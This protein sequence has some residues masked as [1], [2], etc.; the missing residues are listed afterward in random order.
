MTFIFRL[1]LSLLCVSLLAMTP[2]AAVGPDDD[3]DQSTTT[4]ALQQTPQ[5]VNSTTA[6]P[7]VSTASPEQQAKYDDF[8]HTNGLDR[9]NWERFVNKAWDEWGPR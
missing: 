9:Y 4:A 7:S 6:L 3:A 1:T 2:L 5:A 8:L